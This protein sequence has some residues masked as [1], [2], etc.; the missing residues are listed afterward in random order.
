MAPD[1]AKPELKRLQTDGDDDFD[2]FDDVLED[3]G[4]PTKPIPS[5]PPPSA[6]T[7]TP[8]TTFGNRPRNNTRVDAPPISIPGKGPKLPTTTEEE[9]LDEGELRDEFARELAKGMEDLMKEITNGIATGDKTTGDA[10]VAGDATAEGGQEMTDEGRQQAFKAAWEA[11]LVE[12]LNAGGAGEDL[13]EPLGNEG[14]KSKGA[15]SSGS[16]APQMNDFQARIQQAMNKL[17][18]SE[19]N[20]KPESGS[21]GADDDPAS[22]DGLFKSLE[23]L[24]VGE[25]GE[26]EAE[27]AQFLENMM[28][29]LMSKDVLYEPLK[30]LG[31]NYPGY[32]ANP[33]KPLDAEEKERYEKQYSYVK[34]I[35]AVFEKPSYS[36]TNPEDGQTIAR[37]MTEMQN[38]GQPPTEL[39]GD[40]PPGFEGGIPRPGDDCVIA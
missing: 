17:K 26:G 27:L 32:L 30:E 38:H 24:G 16:T 13:G 12:G 33:P 35:L 31:N 39:L 19:S 34:E 10:A 22:L 8:S 25:N 29:Q 3:F 6:T 4:K 15:S 28:S 36:D 40:L 1:Q 20:L 23:D 9:S 18:E 37:L 21:G 7:A 5:A 14:V 11:M 2:E